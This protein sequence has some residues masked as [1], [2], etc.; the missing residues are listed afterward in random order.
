MPSFRIIEVKAAACQWFQEKVK[1]IFL[2]VEFK[3]LLS[4]GKSVLK[5]EK[6]RWKSDHA[7]LYIK[8]TSICTFFFIGISP[9]LTFIEPCNVIYFYGKTNQMHQCIKLFYF[10]DDT[11]HVFI[12]YSLASRQQYLFDLCLLLYEQS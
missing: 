11:P 6:I 12:L 1:H 7:Q 8:V 2:K 5:V 3:S 4:N 10:W 9:N